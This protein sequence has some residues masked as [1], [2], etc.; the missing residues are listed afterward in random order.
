MITAPLRPPIGPRGGREQERDRGGG[1]EEGAA[2]PAAAVA[3]LVWRRASRV[4]V[5]HL[6]EGD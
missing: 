5:P 6:T 3:T 2:Y 4:R 1:E